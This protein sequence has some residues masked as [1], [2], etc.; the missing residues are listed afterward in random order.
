MS[1]LACIER[2]VAGVDKAHAEVLEFPHQHGS[3]RQARSD[4]K[5]P[6]VEQ[7][8]QL[9]TNSPFGT[10]HPAPCRVVSRPPVM[11]T[12]CA[13]RSAWRPANMSNMGGLP[14]C[15]PPARAAPR[16]SAAGGTTSPLSRPPAAGMASPVSGVP[17]AALHTAGSVPGSAI[18]AGDLSSPS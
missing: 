8:L 1:A 12:P 14:L 18:S 11:T 7:R 13:L 17:S 10:D 9:L 4:A 2:D 3:V 15:S 6:S 16:G 5:F